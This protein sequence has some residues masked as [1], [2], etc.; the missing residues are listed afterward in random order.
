MV[1]RDKEAQLR[2]ARQWINIYIVCWV[3]CLVVSPFGIFMVM[4][5]TILNT[6]N[7]GFNV[8]LD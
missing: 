4:T 1:K 8:C 7:D 2:N 5:V 6:I 3:F